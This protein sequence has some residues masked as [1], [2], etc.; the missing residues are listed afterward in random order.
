MV[1]LDAL[2]WQNWQIFHA[3]WDTLTSE[4]CSI[5]SCFK[6]YLRNKHE[7]WN[8]KLDLIAGDIVEADDT[9]GDIQ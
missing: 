9:K 1:N 3:V 5:W 6:S 8:R 4:Q 7:F 2:F